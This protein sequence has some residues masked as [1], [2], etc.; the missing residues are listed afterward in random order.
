MD[1][2]GNTRGGGGGEGVEGSPRDATP[3]F[4][5]QRNADRPH[6]F[7]SHCEIGLIEFRVGESFQGSA[8][9]QQQSQRQLP[10]IP[11]AEA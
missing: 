1:D 9:R 3:A 10:A 11:Q 4:C 7:A 5:G 2:C 6:L 8:L